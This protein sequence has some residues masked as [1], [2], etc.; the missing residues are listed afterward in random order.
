MRYSDKMREWWEKQVDDPRREVALEAIRL[1][2][3]LFDEL[4]CEDEDRWDGIIKEN[5]LY[6]SFEREW[7]GDDVDSKL[8]ACDREFW[9]TNEGY[10][11]LRRELLKAS[12]NKSERA[13][14]DKLVERLDKEFVPLCQK[15]S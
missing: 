9:A 13:T 1:R 12:W 3:E 6:M 4:E 15:Q 5:R 7:F 8:T 11:E 14:F 10:R 2:P